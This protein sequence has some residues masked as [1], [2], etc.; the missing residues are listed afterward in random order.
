M[1]DHEY[2]V[3]Q[4][5]QDISSELSNVKQFSKFFHQKILNRTFYV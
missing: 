3:S 2:T 4:K 1:Y 5:Q